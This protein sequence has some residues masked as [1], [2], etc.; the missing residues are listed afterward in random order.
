MDR[1]S[2]LNQAYQDWKLAFE[3]DFQ[4]ISE[5]DKVW[6][7]LSGLNSDLPQAAFSRKEYADLLSGF[8]DT[9][10]EPIE[11]PKTEAGLEIDKYVEPLSDGMRPFQMTI[12]QDGEI[13]HV[14]G[15]DDALV[16]IEEPQLIN[17]HSDDPDAGELVCDGNIQLLKG[18]FWGWDE[19]EALRTALALFKTARTNY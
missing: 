4:P 7:V 11:V 17:V 15:P 6:V 5:P 12:T 9:E 10:A 14:L 8:L 16:T 18:T 3:E 2:E 19:H 13:V 1:N